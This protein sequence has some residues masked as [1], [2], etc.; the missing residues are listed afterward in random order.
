MGHTGWG[1][2]LTKTRKFEIY[3][4][5][6]NLGGEMIFAKGVAIL[7]GSG[8]GSIINNN[9]TD[10]AH[11]MA[12]AFYN[13]DSVFCDYNNLYTNGTN[14]SSFDTLYQATLAE[15]QVLSGGDSHSVEIPANYLLS[16]DLHLT[17][18]LL[19]G[20]GLYLPDVTKD[21][22]N[23]IRQDPPTIGADE[24]FLTSV[25]SGSFCTTILFYSN[26]VIAGGTMTIY[27]KS[28]D[29][30]IQKLQCE[31][32]NPLGLIARSFTIENTIST[33]DQEQILLPPGI[34]FLI[35]N[36]GLRKQII[37]VIIQ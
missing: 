12:I 16:N 20:L 31:L 24:Y 19:F 4:N 33:I 36:N 2:R 11:G 17:D 26:P 29:S 15:W 21:I 34:Y 14:F 3:Y 8:N 9:T 10:Y 18:A 35:V 32:V 28:P 37:K 22:D 30:K 5:S 1:I 25:N 23:E 7:Y 6:M 27:C 13:T